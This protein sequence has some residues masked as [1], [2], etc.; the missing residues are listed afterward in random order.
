M[1]K[2]ETHLQNCVNN[3][4][5]QSGCNQTKIFSIL[6]HVSQETGKF[7]QNKPN[8]TR[9]G[10]LHKIPILLLAQQ[11]HTLVWSQEHD[12]LGMH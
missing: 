2:K 1:K 9:K 5:S 6:N 8:N 11:E 10:S 3:I 12:V 7:C 4:L